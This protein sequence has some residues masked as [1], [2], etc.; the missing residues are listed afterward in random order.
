MADKLKK[1]YI[2]LLR[3]ICLIETPS[4]N[5]ENI[6]KLVD[7]FERFSKE[8]GYET[9]RFPF[10][11]SGDFLLVK[12]GEDTS[13]KPVLMMAH[14]DTVHKIGAF[15]NEVVRREG[16]WMTGPGVMDCK[17]GIATGFCVMEQIKNI[18]KRPVWLLLTSDEEVSGRYSKAAGY[19]IMTDIAKKCAAVLNLEPGVRDK[20]TVG[21]KGILKMRAEI[22]GVSG[23]AGNAYFEAA[24]AIREAANM[25]LEIENMSKKGG[26]TYNCGI[27]NGGT[28]ANVIP[29]LCVME[30]DIRV[31]TLD[32]MA[33]AEKLM[34]E[35]AKRCV[36]KNT[37]RKVSVIT[38]RPPMKVTDANLKL[39]DIWNKSAKNLGLSEFS[40]LI[41]GGGS[42]AAY[43]VLA[44]VPTLCSCAAVGYNEHTLD[45]KLDLSTLCERAALLCEVIKN[46]GE[47]SL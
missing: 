10:E 38:K 31:S 42:D 40:Q 33:E 29:D 1:K 12:T 28:S 44:G 22:T 5:A 6:N 47:I 13:L 11:K 20:V 2:A 37:K 27:I 39:L 23:H 8:N 45:E 7:M 19:D 24:S 36:V 32:E 16:D 18:C 14:M 41:R 17:G 46:I 43:T 35:A 30:V 15:G 21:R 25:V 26:V 3:D 9:E 34:Y 4:G